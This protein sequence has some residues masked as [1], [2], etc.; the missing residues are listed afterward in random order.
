MYSAFGHNL[1]IVFKN[2]GYE[3]KFSDKFCEIKEFNMQGTFANN[4]LLLMKV[5]QQF[6]KSFIES[7]CFAFHDPFSCVTLTLK[8]MLDYFNEA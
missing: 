1:C 2:C 4:E 3:M 7:N 5:F 6:R 8:L